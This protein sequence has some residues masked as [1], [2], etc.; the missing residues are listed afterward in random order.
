VTRRVVWVQVLIGWLPIWALFTALIIMMHGGTVSGAVLASLRMMLAAALLGLAVNRLTEWLPWPRTIRPSFMLIHLGAAVTFGVAWFVL[1]SV[2][3]SIVIG[4]IAIVLPVGFGP[5][6]VMGVWLYVMVAG[7]AYSQQATERASQAEALA[8]RAQLSALRA[9]L[10][11][12]FL[13]NAL[14]TVVQLIPREPTLAAKAAE[15][16]AGLLRGTIDADR[17]EV[18]LSEEL[19]FVEKYLSIERIR[20]AERLRIHEDVADDAR[21]ATVPSFSVQGLVENAVRHG[22]TPKVEPTDITITGRVAGKSLIV[23]VTDNGS[24]GAVSAN[25]TGL[26]RLRERLTALYDGNATLTT[27][28]LSGG[29]YT[30][31]MTIPL[32]ATD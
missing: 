14:H 13:F 25:G 5:F 11:P 31:M 3:E 22:A 4:H 10:N 19:A 30:A 1:N 2:I 24:G 9:Q 6:V 12:H 26:K 23:T 20:F 28:H 18:P 21:G 16:L 29:G 15:E 32:E 27:G 7:V 17:D 8:A